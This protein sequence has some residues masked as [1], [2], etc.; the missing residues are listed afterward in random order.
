MRFFTKLAAMALSAV[1]ATSPAH[2]V[3]DNYLFGFSPFGVQTLTLNGSI[4][5]TAT[6]TG[7]V[8]QQGL[9]NTGNQNYFVGDCGAGCTPAEQ[10]SY[11]NY[12][13]FNLGQITQT[14]TSAVLSVG[15]GAGYVAGPLS[16]YSLFDVTSSLAS[17][18][19]TRSSG[20]LTGQAIFNDFQ[21]G[22]LFGSRS[23]TSVV[24]NSQVNTTL[25]ASA[26]AAL[27][28]ARGQ[29][30]A[31]GGTLRPG[32]IIPGVPEPASWAMLILGFGIVGASMRRRRRT[33]PM[34]FA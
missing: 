6:D 2:A 9:H 24:Q 22:I 15:N 4:V 33:H 12:F 28:A 14:I 13:V 19:V 30:W 31:I 17:L 18:D 27:N 11:N 8:F 21:S 10:G 29:S 16:T 5:L 1:I 25:N 7:W 20:D 26:V 34:V 32:D 3:V 23:I